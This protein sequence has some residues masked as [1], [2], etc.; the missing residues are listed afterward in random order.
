MKKTLIYQYYYHDVSTGKTVN[1]RYNY[2]DLSS[3]SIYKYALKIGADY[4]FI[5]REIPISP[6]YGIFLPFTENWCDEYRNSMEH[7][8]SLKEKE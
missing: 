8:K 1:A 4:K 7:I 2:Q 5:S 6:F 3:S